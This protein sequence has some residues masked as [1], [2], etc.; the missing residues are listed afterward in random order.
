[1]LQ[2]KEPAYLSTA[3]LP[4]VQYISKLLWHPVS[5]IDI[6]ETYKKQSFR[7]RCQILGS[8]GTLEL[9]IP[10]IKPYGNRS[11]TRDILIEYE[12]NWMLV[13][14]RAILSSYN[15]S[16]FFEIF[17]QELAHLYE[18]KEKFLIDFNQKVL[19]QLM[20]SLD[21]DVS[22]NFSTEFPGKDKGIFDFRNSIHPKESKQ[23]TDPHYK[24]IP[25]YQVFGAKFGF[26]PNLSF[27]DL[28]LNEGPQT[29]AIC[30]NSYQ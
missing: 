21:S 16:P 3:Y 9:S 12:T 8:N 13:H 24:P 14:W 18:K 27:L 25:Y 5:V 26:V 22:I 28:M 20:S 30:K 7:N 4:N 29:I 2:F 6:H 1:M 17:E 15:Q 19:L 10:V 11:A 23:K